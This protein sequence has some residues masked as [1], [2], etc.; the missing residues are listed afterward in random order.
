MVIKTKVFI[1]TCTE[2]IIYL[3]LVFVLL[4]FGVNKSS[5]ERIEYCTFSLRIVASLATS[6]TVLF[7][8]CMNPELH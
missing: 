4:F 8:Y 1:I 7:D 3:V 5:G 2:N 6:F